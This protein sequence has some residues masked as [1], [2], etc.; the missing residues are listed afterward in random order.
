MA[1]LNPLLLEYR[2]KVY[3]DDVFFIYDVILIINL[4][5]FHTHNDLHLI[6]KCMGQSWNIPIENMQSYLR[7]LQECNTTFVSLFL[8]MQTGIYFKRMTE[9]TWQIM[10]PILLKLLSPMKP[11][12][13]L[14][15]RIFKIHFVILTCCFYSIVQ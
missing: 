8:K 2:I 9:F 11:G 1:N 10:L 12:L 6:C 15:V 3:S 14:K 5:S 13:I 4:K 7:C